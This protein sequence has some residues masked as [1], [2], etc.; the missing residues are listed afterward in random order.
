MH[1][2]EST[3]T[4]RWPY[5][6]FYIEIA[7]FLGLAIAAVATGI[8]ALFISA[9]AVGISSLVI[10]LFTKITVQ[11]GHEGLTVLYGPLSWP[12]Q[13]IPLDDIEHASVMDDLN[14]WKWGGWGYRGM[15]R[16][17]R[18]AAVNLRRGPAIRL[19]LTKRRLFIVTVDEP[20]LGVNVLNQA[21]ELRP[22]RSDD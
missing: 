3:C 18:K 9:L 20:A 4:A 11:T 15:L 14:P 5:V 10:L 16:I 17:F 7:V 8:G 13:T 21:I 1:T 22:K 2:W 6:I 12:R 19:E